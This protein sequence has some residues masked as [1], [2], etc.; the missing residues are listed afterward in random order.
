MPWKLWT[1]LLV[2]RSW[3]A[4]RKSQL[5]ISPQDQLRQFTVKIGHKSIFFPFYF[6]LT[7]SRVVT[8]QLRKWCLCTNLSN[9]TAEC[10]SIFI[11]YNVFISVWLYIFTYRWK[12]IFSRLFA[13]IYWVQDINGYN[14]ITVWTSQTTCGDC[15]VHSKK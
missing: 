6:K 14:I 15:H 12:M 13:F 5:A 10:V 8:L 1:S 3:K 4:K 2:S 7:F 11:T 9:Y